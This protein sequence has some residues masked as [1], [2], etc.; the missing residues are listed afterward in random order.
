[1]SP[2]YNII[3]FSS[4]FNLVYTWR[5]IDE[6][7]SPCAYPEDIDRYLEACYHYGNAS[8][9]I[10]VNGTV[11]VIQFR[12]LQQINKKT[13]FSRKIKRDINPVSSG[14][15]SCTCCILFILTIVLLTDIKRYIILRYRFHYCRIFI[16]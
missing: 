1:M 10:D 7:G 5:W 9:E 4:F 11:Y 16:T 8:T 15:F 3:E 6:S 14:R 13:G 12:R 2:N